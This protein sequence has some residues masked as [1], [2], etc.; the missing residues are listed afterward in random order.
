MTDYEAGDIVLVD[1]GFSEGT[2]S[3]KRPALVISTGGYHKS[4][5]E[6][7]VA[8]ITSNTKRVLAGDTRIQKW[9]KAGLIH[10][11]L[12]TGIIRTTKRSVIV[13]KLGVLS[14][15]DF[16]NVRKSFGRVLAL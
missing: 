6:A 16:T 8:A 13:R 5:A 7:I 12:V 14:E 15:Q 3:K 10:P 9:E 4:R 2:G 1:F 11:S